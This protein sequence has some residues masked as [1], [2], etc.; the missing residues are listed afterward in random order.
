MG[1]RRCAAGF[2]LEYTEENSSMD[3][4]SVYKTPAAYKDNRIPSGFAYY[5]HSR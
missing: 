2:D 5:R 4:N 1:G 3:S